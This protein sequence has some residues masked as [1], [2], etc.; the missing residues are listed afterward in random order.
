MSAI[1]WSRV[2]V[3]KDDTSRSGW[4]SRRRLIVVLIVCVLLAATATAI[5]WMRSSSS[6]AFDKLIPDDWKLTSQSGYIVHPCL[7]SWS[8]CGQIKRTYATGTTTAQAFNELGSH[9][10]ALHWIIRTAP[11]TTGSQQLELDARNGPKNWTATV[12]FTL[13]DRT[14]TAIYIEK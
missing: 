10:E 7:G 3:T 8:E 4:K 5:L 6:D 9:L 11:R 13:A 12:H 14:A 2:A 1:V